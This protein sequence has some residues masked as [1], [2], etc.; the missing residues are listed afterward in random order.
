MCEPDPKI[1]EAA[2]QG[3]A[4][5]QFKLAEFY[6]QHDVDDYPEAVKWYR[7][8]AAQGYPD[9]DFDFTPIRDDGAAVSIG[10]ASSGWIYIII[11]YGA[12]VVVIR[13]SDVFDPYPE[14]YNWLYCVARGDTSNIVE[15]DEE[16]SAKELVVFSKEDDNILF[17]VRDYDYGEEFEEDPDYPRTYIDI[18]CP[19]K[20]LVLEFC[21]K[22]RKYFKERFDPNQWHHDMPDFDFSIIEDLLP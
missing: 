16:G 13:T 18:V 14:I 12:Q 4:E 5:A 19:R 8:A 10:P 20:D 21:S 1:L 2:Q 22:F 9:A 15:I 6:S 3:D 7:K 17:Q 11:E